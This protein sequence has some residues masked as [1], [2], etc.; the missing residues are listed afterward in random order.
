MS[1]SHEALMSAGYSR[2][3]RPGEDPWL[4]WSQAL[5]QKRI[6]VGQDTAYFINVYWY[7][8]RAFHPSNPDGWKIEVQFHP[9]DDSHPTFNVNLLHDED[10]TPESIEAWYANVYR[11]L[12]CSPHERSPMSES[13]ASGRPGE[14]RQ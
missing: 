3:Y 11:A 12:G 10:M 8:F 14:V 13:P 2:H 5:Y 4:N 9:Y 7:D 6:R 1:L